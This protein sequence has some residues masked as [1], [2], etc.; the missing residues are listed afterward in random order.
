MTGAQGD[1]GPAG[2]L[3]MADFYGMVASS[4][5]SSGHAVPFALVHR[6]LEFS[7]TFQR[8]FRRINLL[9]LD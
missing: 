4:G 6:A 8:S 7:P 2:T 3:E 9:T 5:I 1:P